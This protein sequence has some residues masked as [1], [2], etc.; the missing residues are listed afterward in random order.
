MD[1]DHYGILRGIK[2]P[3]PSFMKL[4]LVEFTKLKHYSDLNSTIPPLNLLF[5][6]RDVNNITF[7]NPYVLQDIE[8]LNNITVKGNC[9][10]DIIEKNKKKKTECY[11]KVTHLLDP[12]QF[13]KGEASSDRIQN[14]MNQA[15]VET[16]ASWVLGKLRYENISPHFNLFY[17]AFSAKASKYNYNVTDEIETHR[18]YKWFW[19]N[20]ETKT[21]ELYIEGDND[22]IKQELYDEIMVKPDYCLDNNDS[23]EELDDSSELMSDIESIHSINQDILSDTIVQS[24]EN[25]DTE[26]SDSEDKEEDDEEDEDDY[27]VYLTFKNFPVMMILTEKNVST[28]DDLLTNYEEVGAEPGNQLWEE[29]WSAWLFQVI[30]ALCVA[31][32]LYG[33]THNDLHSNN[34]VWSETNELYLFYK[35]NDGTLFKVPTYGK[36]FKIIDFGRSIFSINDTP[37][38]S[39][40]FDEG[41][42][43]ATQYNFP[44]LSNNSDKPIVYP[45]PSF[46]LA[47]LSISIFET[48]FPT[49]PEDKKN[50]HVLS[51][52][53]NRIVKE[54]KSDLFNILWTWLLDNEGNNILWDGENNER[55]PD[56]ELYVH[57]SEKCRNAIPKDQL[58][59]KPFSKF[60]IK[61]LPKDVNKVY[62]LFI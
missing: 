33:F 47:R 23:V 60:M 13:I 45:N 15:Y 56:F 12:I 38:I 17:G 39:D 14:P 19:E 34:I 9:L 29:K 42:D 24:T 53:E 11:L 22:E 31:Q 44:P 35:M 32:T 6:L 46:D 20:I 25:I 30:S 51:T 21:I 36:L 48:I 7:Q 2:L 27:N 26:N 18:M 5:D 54:T 58:Y 55:F 61:S 50:G 28:L 8:L 62:N 43:A 1:T 10:A 59:K 52:E 37:F 16:V 41:N 49:K 40:D 57:I 4:N 3:L